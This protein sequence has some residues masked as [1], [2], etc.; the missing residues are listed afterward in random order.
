MSYPKGPDSAEGVAFL[1]SVLLHF[2]AIGSASLGPQRGELKVEFYL[3]SEIE[4]GR[5]SE[6][7]ETFRMSWDLFFELLRVKPTVRRFTRVV[8]YPGEDP[9]SG[10]EVEIVRVVRDLDTFTYE[11]LAMIVDLIRERFLPV[12]IEGEP[13]DVPELAYQERVLRR[14][15]DNI[16]ND[17]YAHWGLTGFRDEMRVLVYASEEADSR[18]TGSVTMEDL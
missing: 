4:P 11:E 9:D 12:L 13:I 7:V 15:L 14:S 3:D 5:F 17:P 2:P 10:P 6:F 8:D 16:R 18:V 1:T